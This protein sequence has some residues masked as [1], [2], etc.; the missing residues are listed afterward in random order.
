[1]WGLRQARRRRAAGFQLG[2]EADRCNGL[3]LM[4]GRRTPAAS[5]S[6]F[7]ILLTGET[8]SR[9]Y[10]NEIHVQ[11]LVSSTIFTQAIAA[12]IFKVYPPTLFVRSVG[13]KVMLR[14]CWSMANSSDILSDFDG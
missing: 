6:A 11:T 2:Q 8:E 10:F 14:A 1:L 12:K 5:E 9:A 4:Y 7:S 13:R 3:S